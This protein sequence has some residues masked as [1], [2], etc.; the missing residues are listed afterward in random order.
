MEYFRVPVVYWVIRTFRN[1]SETTY[2][3]AE[4]PAV[5]TC[6]ES[7]YADIAALCGRW[8]LVGVMNALDGVYT[9][10]LWLV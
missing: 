2:R 1:C 5:S 10:E 6:I 9:M 8:L 7:G 3:S 4:A